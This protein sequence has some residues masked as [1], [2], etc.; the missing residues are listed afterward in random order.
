MT[1]GGPP[2]VSPFGKASPWGRIV[3]ALSDRSNTGPTLSTTVLLEWSSP[4]LGLMWLFYG[5]LHILNPLSAVKQVPPQFPWKEE[6]FAISG[7]CELI[8][9][10][11]AMVPRWRRLSALGQMVL[12]VV[13]I[14]AVVYLLIDDVPARDLFKWILAHDWLGVGACRVIVVVN[15]LIFFV[16]AR[17]IYQAD[18]RER[19]A[20]RFPF[21]LPSWRWSWPSTVRVGNI[22]P[23]A[24]VAWI[25]LA[26]NIAGELAVRLS[27]WR[28]D[29]PTFWS[30]ACLAGGAVIG[31][32]FGVPRV[33]VVRGGN[34]S[35]G[36]PSTA[37]GIVYTPNANLESLS[38]WLTKII[39]GAGLVELRQIVAWVNNTSLSLAA[40]LQARQ[41]GND[42]PSPQEAHSYALALIVYFSFAG[43]IQGYLL[44]RM[45]LA[46]AF[47]GD[48]T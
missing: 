2:F 44:T 37:A 41:S 26:A 20:V 21:A 36:V 35:E 14:P 46:K 43:L 5:S 6:I 38:D 42:K 10:F 13:Y 12:L 28:A 39:V 17:A 15:N 40:G 33:E 48:R 45:F 18:V 1:G 11:G 9:G 23:E 47:R 8:I 30:M 4:L 31:F 19:G 29:T 25:M 24:L 27:P 22:R 7:I 34:P 3:G 16:W 32:I